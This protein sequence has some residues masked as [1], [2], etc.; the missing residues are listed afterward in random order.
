MR[1]GSPDDTLFELGDRRVNSQRAGT[2]IRFQLARIW[3]ALRS[4]FVSSSPSIRMDSSLGTG[5][6]HRSRHL[7]SSPSARYRLPFVLRREADIWLM[8]K[9]GRAHV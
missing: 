5:E 4:S 2:T 1:S 3:A 8:E 7:T 9:I 6:G